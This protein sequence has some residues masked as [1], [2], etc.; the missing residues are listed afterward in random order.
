M[1]VMPSSCLMLYGV[2]TQAKSSEIDFDYE[3][4]GMQR[5]QEFQRLVAAAGLNE[6]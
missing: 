6:P 3:A 1:S 5:L 2:V 4:Y